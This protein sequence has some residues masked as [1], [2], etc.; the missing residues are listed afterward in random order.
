MIC[1]SY[2]SNK[3]LN[4]S[5]NKVT[6]IKETILSIFPKITLQESD[7]LAILDLLKHDK[8]NL[9]GDV[10]FVLLYDFEDYKIDCKVSQELIIASL[11]YYNS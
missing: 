6:E 8:K 4:F 3:L 10:N 5:T 11:I 1:E 7:F 2:I 9:S